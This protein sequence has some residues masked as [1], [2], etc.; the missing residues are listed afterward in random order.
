MWP[1]GKNESKVPINSLCLIG[2]MDDVDCVTEAETAFRIKISDEEAERTRTVGQYF[3]LVWSKLDEMHKTIP[4]AEVHVWIRICQILRS[5]S[6]HD[7]DINFET[8]FFAEHVIGSK[9]NG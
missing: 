5:I 1:F 8:T 6:G 3:E 4:F 7:G 9:A 2:D